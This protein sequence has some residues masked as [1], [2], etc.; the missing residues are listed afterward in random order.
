MPLGSLVSLPGGV[1]HAGPAVMASRKNFRAVLFF[2]A[3][4]GDAEGYN[5]DT[6]Y[7]R[8][9]LIGDIIMFTWISMKAKERKYMLTRWFE[10]GIR[11]DVGN[12][13]ESMGHRALFQIGKA[14]KDARS[15]KERSLL[16]Q[17]VAE[18]PCWKAEN[19]EANWQTE[20]FEYKLPQVNLEE[21]NWPCGSPPATP[22][23]N[24][25]DAT[26]K[27]NIN[28]EGEGPPTTGKE[29]I[30]LCLE[31]EDDYD[32]QDYVFNYSQLTSHNQ[33]HATAR[34]Q[35]LKG[36]PDEKTM[37]KIKEVMLPHPKAGKAGVSMG[38]QIYQN[39]TVSEIRYKTMDNG[40]EESERVVRRH[41]TDGLL[42]KG[43][44]LSDA[45]VH[46]YRALLNRRDYLR[47]GSQLGKRS[48]IYN[49]FFPDTLDMPDTY[50]TQ[51]RYGDRVPGKC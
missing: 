9:T 38:K 8:T 2:T 14:I 16:I 29:V 24:A 4:P 36:P 17:A 21:T 45:I 51:R 42:K 1:P 34:I 26:N 44:Y 40:P 39:E 28:E 49:T 22:N 32:Y 48:W 23:D 47:H 3:A 37:E 20:G 31:D 46:Y 19:A 15:H 41:F 5:V 50:T 27:D 43:K 12:A 18:D 35:C 30:C 33:L 25:L 11:G 10:E 13:M 7:C 6:Q